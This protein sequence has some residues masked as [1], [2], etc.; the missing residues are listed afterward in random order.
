MGG[1]RVFKS[2]LRIECLGEIDELNSVIGIVLSEIQKS[3]GKNQKYRPKL[4]SE[5]EKIQND[6]LEIGSFFAN[7]QV[8]SQELVVSGLLKRVEKLE[9]LIDK[10]SAQMP[11]L[12]K[13]ILPGGGSVGA[14]LHLSRSACRRAERKIVA[15]NNKE[16]IDKN[17]LI[18]INR[19]SDLLFVMARFANFK[20][21]RKEI[22]WLQSNEK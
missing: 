15:L 3:K 6:L 16:K 10:M 13:F 8:G 19:L 2:D 12:R 4:K 21:K 5:L 7:P 18:Y 9:D 22:V 17:I 20:E 14:M 1:K 11:E